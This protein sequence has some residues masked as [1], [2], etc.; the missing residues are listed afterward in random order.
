ML[1]EGLFT[2]ITSDPGVKA[3]LNG[4]TSVYPNI[5]PDETS[6]PYIV[7]TQ[8][9]RS[10][11]LTYQG[12]NRLQ[13]TRIQFS[14][15]GA[16]YKTAKSLAGAVKNLL[17]GFTGLLG[18]GTILEHSMPVSEHDEVERELK[19]TVYGIHLDYAFWATS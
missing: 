11:I 6:L 19:A 8:I 14:C 9:A 18:D 7:Y 4:K 13:E 12:V 1:V 15:Y 3:A 17:D 2:L 16:S 5:A 10:V